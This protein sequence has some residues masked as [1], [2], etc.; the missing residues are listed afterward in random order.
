MHFLQRAPLRLLLNRGL[1]I[2]VWG[3]Y[4]PYIGAW[5][6]PSINGGYSRGGCLNLS[7]RWHNGV[8]TTAGFQQAGG[9]SNHGFSGLLHLNHQVFIPKREITVHLVMELGL[10][11]N[12]VHATL[13]HLLKANWRPWDG[14]PRGPPPPYFVRGWNGSPAWFPPLVTWRCPSIVGYP[15]ILA[16]FLLLDLHAKRL[17]VKEGMGFVG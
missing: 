11:L 7:I 17:V 10:I 4:R 1:Y 5:E 8:Q 16:L 15:R 6:V 13:I 2:G 9:L 14:P 12:G 3:L